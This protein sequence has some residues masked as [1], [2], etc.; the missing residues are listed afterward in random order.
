MASGSSYIII[1]VVEMPT[2]MSWGGGDVEYNM[3]D[4]WKEAIIMST[5]FLGLFLGTTNNNVWYIKGNGHEYISLHIT[6]VDIGCE[7]GTL[8]ETDNGNQVI[9]YC[10]KNRPVYPIVSSSIMTVKF[11][12]QP[13]DLFLLMEGFKGYYRIEVFHENLTYLATSQGRGM[14]QCINQYLLYGIFH[15][16]QLD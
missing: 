8:L 9:Q 10:N 5:T 16:Y 2:S 3:I 4:T 11:R 15:P 14:Y 7:S 6:D 13:P 1:I 12:N